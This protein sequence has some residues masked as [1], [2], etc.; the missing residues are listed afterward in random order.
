VLLAPSSQSLMHPFWNRPK[1][2]TDQSTSAILQ[3]FR[4]AATSPSWP[5]EQIAQTIHQNVLGITSPARAAAKRS[6]DV[7][8]RWGNASSVSISRRLVPCGSPNLSQR[9]QSHVVAPSRFHGLLIARTTV[10]IASANSDVGRFPAPRSAPMG[11]VLQ[12]DRPSAE[13]PCPFLAYRQTKF[14]RR[15]SRVDTPAEVGKIAGKHATAVR[16]HGS[17]ARGV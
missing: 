7:R 13:R 1:T 17:K 10:K 4:R 6:F 9:L 2:E 16:R 3:A 12:K 14:H 11:R 15:T 5:L 8:D